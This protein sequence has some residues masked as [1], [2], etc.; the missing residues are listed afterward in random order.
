MVL[1]RIFGP[2]TKS[3]TTD[4]GELQNKELHKSVLLAEYC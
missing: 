3:V 4:W 2:K 1:R